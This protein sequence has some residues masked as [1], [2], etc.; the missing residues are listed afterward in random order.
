MLT[1]HHEHREVGQAFE[2][3]TGG[4]RACWRPNGSMDYPLTSDG[5]HLLFEDGSPRSAVAV[6][7]RVIRLARTLR[8]ADAARD[9]P[10]NA[11]T[12]DGG[13]LD[14]GQPVRS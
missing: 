1:A 3:T 12:D 2:G 14:G 7:Q 5:E 10:T 11:S 8:R 6:L 4:P 9:R 13:R